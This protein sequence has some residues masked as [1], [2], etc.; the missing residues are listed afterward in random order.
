MSDLEEARRLLGEIIEITEGYGG[1]FGLGEGKDM[2]RI[3]GKAIK[4]LALL[5]EGDCPS[6]VEYDDDPACADCIEDDC[7]NEM[8]TE[9]PEKEGKQEG[10]CC[11]R[12][13]GRTIDPINDRSGWSRTVIYQDYDPE[14]HTYAMGLEFWICPQCREP[15]TSTNA[16]V[17]KKCPRCGAGMEVE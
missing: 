1:I 9:E 13:C 14:Y 12:E 7:P 15:D 8:R 2:P 16:T 17:K 3:K 6:D 10:D 5:E 11:C 4:T